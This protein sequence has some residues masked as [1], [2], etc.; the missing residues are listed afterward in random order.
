M[1]SIADLALPNKIWVLSP[2]GGELWDEDSLVSI[3]WRTYLPEAGTAVRFELWHASDFIMDLGIG[4]DPDGSGEHTLYLLLIPGSDDYRV[5][6][7]SLWDPDYSDMSDSPF[8]ISGN[9]IQVID[10]NGAEQWTVGEVAAIHWKTNTVFAGT[11]VTL[12]LWRGETMIQELA[13]AWD[14]EGEALTII[15]VPEIPTGA[16]YKVRAT[17][18]WDGTYWDVSDA[19][20]AIVNPS[21]SRTAVQPELWIYYQ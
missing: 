17:S 2:N 9:S 19:V 16:N 10:P 1:F 6:I 4:W 7:E 20:F 12:A 15:T 14:P 8:I 21:D 3:R 18:L 5:R 11:A 13:V